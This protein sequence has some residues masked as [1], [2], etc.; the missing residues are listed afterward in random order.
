LVGT[1]DGLDVGVFVSVGRSVEVEVG[2]VVRVEVGGDVR[3]NVGGMK[4]VFDG[5]GVV[6]IVGV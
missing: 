3:V 4:G 1:G 6:L 5:V 2:A